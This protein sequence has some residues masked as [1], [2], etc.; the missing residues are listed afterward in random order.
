M[1][2]LIRL[3]NLRDEG[4]SVLVMVAIS[5]V[6]LLGFTALVIDGGR[7]YSEK[8][9]LQKALDASVLAG[10]S[11]L[12]VSQSKAVST[13]IDIASKNNLT[14][15][16]SDI[17]TG[18]NYI[19]IKKTISKSLTFARIIGIETAEVPAFAKAQLKGVC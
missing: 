5:M 13:A 19:Q 7:L 15:T 4:G 16:A 11:D 14:L 17:K 18:P 8:S 1:K 10:A 12:T 6:A 3:L 9:Q 2:R